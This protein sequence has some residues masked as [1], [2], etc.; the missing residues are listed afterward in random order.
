IGGGRH[1][2]ARHGGNGILR[3]SVAGVETGAVAVVVGSDR[4]VTGRE[5]RAGTTAGRA[6]N[7]VHRSSEVYPVDD[8][9]HGAGIYCR[10]GQW[11]R[12]EERRVAKEGREG[13][14]GE[15]GTEEDSTASGGNR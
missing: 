4:V 9:L 11:V 8:E 10:R 1:R 5:R 2:C 13:R 3:S 7:D 12:S 6:G 14:G 15:R